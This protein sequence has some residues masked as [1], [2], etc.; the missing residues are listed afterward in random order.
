MIWGQRDFSGLS[1]FASAFGDSLGSVGIRSRIYP[2]HRQHQDQRCRIPGQ[3]AG[4]QEGSPAEAEFKM[5][6]TD[7]AVHFSGQLTG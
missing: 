1:N 4:P 2:G 6:E 3:A 7:A 5:A